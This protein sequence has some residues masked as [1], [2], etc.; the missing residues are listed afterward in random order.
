MILGYNSLNEKI[1]QTKKIIDTVTNA[2]N[3]QEEK[4]ININNSIINL[5]KLNNDNSNAVKDLNSISAQ[6]E[7]LSKDIEF[8]IS[9]AKI[10]E[11]IKLINC[12]VEISTAISKYKRDH[13][14]FKTNNF[15][16]LDEF[17]AF[18]VVDYKSCKLG[19]WIIQVEKDEEAFTK[20]KNWEDLKRSHKKVHDA[21]QEYINNNADDKKE[22]LLKNNAIQI[23]YAT[24]EVFS[25]LNE[26][27]K[28]K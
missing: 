14:E 7:D 17:K 5:G 11:D 15:N 13:I 27:L 3:I 24:Q 6:I 1:N 19:K 21:V 20:E 26:L 18:D 28:C 8:T 2:S 25:R 23:E 10:D 12:S 22:D 16:K 4:M 9:K